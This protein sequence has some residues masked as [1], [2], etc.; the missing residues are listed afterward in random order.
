MEVIPGS[1]AARGGLHGEDLILEVDG[2]PVSGMGDLQRLMDEGTIGR[3]LTLLV[4]RDGRTF[5]VAIVPD[6]LGS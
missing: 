2:L 6:E 5:D 3:P 1:P 4:H